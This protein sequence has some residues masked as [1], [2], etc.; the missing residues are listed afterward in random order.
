MSEQSIDR[1]NGKEDLVV[2]ENL[3]KYFPVRGG[4]MQRVVAWV[5][6]VDDI[7]FTVRK[8]ETL[9]LV[10]ESGCGKTT[11]GRTML[12]LI[13]PTGG[14][15]YIDGVNVFDLHGRE[16][17][18]MR[19]NMQI[20]FQDP[21]ASLDPRMPIGESIA[22]GL[23]IH[24]VGSPRERF[25][26]VI[27]NLR[28]VGLEDYHARRYPHEFSGGQRQRIGI[29]RALALQ[30]DFIVCD[31]PVSALDVSIQ[32][33]VLNIL[34]D[35]QAEYGLTYLFIAHNLSV[36]EHISHRVA[37]MYLGIMVEL[38]TREELFRNPLHPYTQALMSAIPVPDPD[39]K[40]ARIILPGDVPSPLNPP[41]GCR[42]H[43]R[44]P[45]AM[46][47]CS[48]ATPPFIEVSE[49]HSTACWR[50]E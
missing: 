31:E 11:V 21:Y 27:E 25:E 15:V 44:C 12:R 29:A 48:V 23:K 41:S 39:M 5:Q 16:M 50:V 14:A 34:N 10:G 36:V 8:G 18:K 4:L 40:R 1:K 22:E 7:S 35:L 45:V 2:V 20:I 47:H 42:F 3:V 28:K 37:V 38:T 6:A 43:P 26:L 46:E 13:E 33:Q 9:G 17:K 49:D 19:R 32:S 30:P 24:K